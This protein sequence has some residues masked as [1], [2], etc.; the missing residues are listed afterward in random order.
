MSDPW[1]ALRATTRARIGLGRTGDALPVKDVLEF[2]LAHA[3]ARDAV[4]TPLDTAAVA[5]SIAPL[6]SVT[7]RSQAPDR[8]TY[9]R[10]PDLGRQLDPA[11][12]ADLT[13]RCDAVFVI[14]DGLSPI[15]VQLH[16]APLLNACLV[17]LPDWS[18]APVV[19]ATQARVAL[20]DEIGAALQ[21][22]ICAVLIGERPGLSVAHSLGVY[23]TYH[24]RIGRRD[25]E[26]NCISNIHADGLSYA[27]AADMMAWLMTEARRRKL[28]GIALKDDRATAIQ[29]SPE[30]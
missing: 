12:R 4:H 10:R 28:T 20:G 9:L 23:L 22:G 16:A 8:D 19:I 25:S 18:V 6:P 7:V 30:R 3:R 17:L 21:A 1:A 15:A 11:C 13:G 29:S 5:R 2:Q 27:A 26:R 14:A 24:P